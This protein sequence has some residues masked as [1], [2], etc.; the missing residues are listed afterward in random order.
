ME[1]CE[2]CG[3]TNDVQAFGVDHT[4]LCPVHRIEAERNVEL[5]EYIAEMQHEG[6]DLGATFGDLRRGFQRWKERQLG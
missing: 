3:A 1:P 5:H 2:V 6:A 4:P